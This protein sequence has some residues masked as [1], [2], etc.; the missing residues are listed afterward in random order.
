MAVAN[1]SLKDAL[2][3]A[4]KGAI[5]G[6]ITAG[7]LMYVGI[8]QNEQ[9]ILHVREETRVEIH[10]LKEKV[11]EISAKRILPD[12][13]LRINDLKN[14]DAQHEMRLSTLEQFRTEGRR[15]TRADCDKLDEKIETVREFKTQCLGRLLSME[16]RVKRVEEDYKVL[17][18]QF[19]HSAI[20][21]VNNGKSAE[22]GTQ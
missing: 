9:A 20:E 10:A 5:S 16:H 2:A 19:S 1:G 3:T 13:E 11:Q 14:K 7:G 18:S 21:F 22:T 8:L 12:A 17:Y 6:G 15:C 4:F